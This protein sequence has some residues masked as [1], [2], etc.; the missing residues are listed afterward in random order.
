[1]SWACC[2]IPS[3]KK[4]TDIIAFHGTDLPSALGILR[5]GV[6]KP[7]AGQPGRSEGQPLVCCSTSWKCACRYP[8]KHTG[9]RFVFEF[10]YTTWPPTWNNK[11]T[12][13]VKQYGFADPTALHLRSVTAIGP[14]SEPAP[15]PSFHDVGKNPASTDE[16]VRF[17]S[18]SHSIGRWNHVRHDCSQTCRPCRLPLLGW[19]L[20]CCSNKC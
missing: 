2:R 15:P 5:G 13:D 7:S 3:N 14:A 20:A 4:P 19:L 1:M 17:D 8:M 6:F 9:D 16:L 12:S 18:S 11:K 10:Q